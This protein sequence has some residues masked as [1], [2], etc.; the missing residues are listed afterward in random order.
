MELYA[1]CGYWVIGYRGGRISFKICDFGLKIRPNG[2]DYFIENSS[3]HM[4]QK[5]LDTLEIYHLA[6]KIGKEIWLAIES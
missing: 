1:L 4:E 6:V 3:L 2:I 5:S